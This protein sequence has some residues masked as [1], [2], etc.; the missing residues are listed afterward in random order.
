MASRYM[1]F[2]RK[3]AKPVMV[4]MG[5][6]CMITFVIAGALTDF[7]SNAMRRA[8]E[9]ERNPVMVTWA[10][11][12]VRSSEIGSLQYRHQLTYEFLMQVVVTALQRG[13]KPFINGRPVSMEQQFI[14]VGIPMDNSEETAMQ[15]MVLAEEANRLGIVVGQDAVK[16][17][18]RQISSPELRDGDWMEIGNGVIERHKAGLSVLQLFEHL[19]YELKAQHV[20]NLAMTGLYAHS[21]GPI[22]PPGEAFELFNRINRRYTIEAFPLPVEHFVKDVKG[23]PSA[24]EIQKLFD[25]GKFRDP[26]PNIDEPGFHKPH[27]LAFGYVKVG[28]THFLDEAKTQITDEQIEEAYK[29]DIEQGLHKVQELPPANPPTAEKTESDET[30][31][32]PGNATPENK[33]APKDSQPATSDK[34]PS[35]SPPP[36]PDAKSAPEKS[37]SEK[38]TPE[39]TSPEKS[40]NDNG[41]CE[42][43]SEQEATQT[44]PAQPAPTA[45]TTGSNQ[46][47]AKKSDAPATAT[48]PATTPPADQA[49]APANATDAQTPAKE[50]KFKPLSEVRDQILTR[51][52]QPIA[53]EARKKATAEIVAAVEKYG[54]TYRRYLDAKG[55]GKTDAKEP[56]KLE[57]APIAAKYHFEIGETPLVDQYQIAEYEIGQKVQ[58]LDFE[59]LQQRRQIRMLSFADIAFPQES[60]L[61]KPEEVRS[62]EPDT[63]YTYWRTAEEKPA[64][65]TL[66]EARPQVIEFWKK[67]QAFE[68]AKVE[69]ERLAE[70]ARSKPLGEV[71]PDSTKI[72]TTPPFAWMTPGQFGMGGPEL[73]QVP[74]IELA[75][76]EFMRAVFAIPLNESGT[77][78]NQAKSK[79]FVVRVLAQDPDD[80][81]LKSRFLESG[82]NELVRSM[83]HF[84]TLMTSHEWYRGVAKQYEVKWQRPPDERRR[85]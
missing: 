5:V 49:A 80:E 32:D 70:K 61:Y 76:Q 77:A 75:G 71:V 12:D 68:L 60:P 63:A 3:N 29:K 48:K 19:A 30:K 7:A 21:V 67:R 1:N 52:A 57:L 65:T 10:K 46:A 41:G 18:L 31:K 84:E 79:I 9:N 42:T 17:F 78:P 26:N 23:E 4:V 6:V 73:S 33:D 11:G 55:M 44:T 24:A 47:D 38:S 58:Q 27:K 2:L 22:I 25:E 37:S 39:K 51:L 59:A 72:I 8:D 82:Y 62:S 15:T 45:T 20:R 43:A 14:D 28:F 40:S 85:M 66:K 81:Q 54:K 36:Q 34:P 64:D 83:A 13:G 35:T 50:Q 56:E 53:E 74:G 16:E 69:A